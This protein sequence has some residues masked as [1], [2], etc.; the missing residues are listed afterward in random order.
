[1][2]LTF[3]YTVVLFSILVQGSTIEKLMKH[4][5]A[6]EKGKRHSSPRDF[7]GQS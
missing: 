5:I 1:M 3:T 6:G 7:F 2:I 4:I